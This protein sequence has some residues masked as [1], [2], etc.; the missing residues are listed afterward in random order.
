MHLRFYR[1][2]AVTAPNFAEE[3]DAVQKVFDIIHEE[4]R[5]AIEAVQKG[6]ASPVW[7]QHFYAPFWDTLHHR[8]NQLIMEDMEKSC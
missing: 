2:E 7:R 8:F 1:P 6:R 3:E 5:L 4:D